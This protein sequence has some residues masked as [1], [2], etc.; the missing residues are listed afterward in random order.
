MEHSMKSTISSELDCAKAILK[1]YQQVNDTSYR[2]RK[3]KI[4]PAI[5]T[6]SKII[7][8]T[9]KT[10]DL[11]VKL[12]ELQEKYSLLLNELNSKEAMLT[13]LNRQLVD[14]T[15][16]L[17]QLQEDFENVIGQFNHK[18]T[19]NTANMNVFE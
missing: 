9:P 4:R 18:F 2:G 19:D 10:K 12:T 13:R 5:N 17:E 8:K 14:R 7:Q 15:T 3:S 16:H 1:T 11:E 6:N